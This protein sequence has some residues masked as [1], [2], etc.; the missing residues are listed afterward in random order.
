MNE[1][2]VEPYEEFG[3]E[4]DDGWIKIIQP[5][6]DYINNY[7]KDKSDENKIIICQIKEK[8]GELRFYV[9]NSTPEVDKMISEAEVKCMHTCEL[10]GSEEDVGLVISSGWYTTM[11]K[12]C[13]ID[14]YLNKVRNKEKTFFSLNKKLYQVKN[15]ELIEIKKE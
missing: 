12:K 10:C 8:F 14:Y 7:N 4:I 6:I 5:I 9:D 11:C 1:K 13:F 15:N 2:L 3:L